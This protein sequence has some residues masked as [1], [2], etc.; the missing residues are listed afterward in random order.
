[1]KTV[2]VK[3]VELLEIMIK[4]K[5]KHKANVEDL[6]VTAAWLLLTG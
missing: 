3:R 1:M 5:Q 2:K 6:K 4:N